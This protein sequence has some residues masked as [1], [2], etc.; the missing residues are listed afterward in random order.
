VGRADGDERRPRADR[1]ADI[2][3]PDHEGQRVRL[4]GLGRDSP[5][6][7]VWLRRDGSAHG[8]GH[9]LRFASRA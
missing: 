2:A 4:V 5:V 3:L 1:L 8:R 7:L 9:A 6:A